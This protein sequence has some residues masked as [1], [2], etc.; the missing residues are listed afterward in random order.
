M[1]VVT[2]GS[3]VITRLRPA[4]LARYS[5]ESARQADTL[6]RN[7]AEVAQRV[8]GLGGLR[9][10]RFLLHYGFPPYSVGEVRPLRGPG[11][12]RPPGCIQ[13]VQTLAIPDQ[14]KQVAADTVH[15][16]LDNGKRNK[17][18]KVSIGFS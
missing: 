14:R 11:R 3:Q 10:E 1:P 18:R 12:W 15:R 8:D 13:S 6:A 17:I 9:D 7:A 2:A 4:A 16:G 5:A